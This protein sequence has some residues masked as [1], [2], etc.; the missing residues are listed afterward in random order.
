[1]RWRI[2]C[3]MV[4][5][6]D[7]QTKHLYITTS[8]EELCPKVLH[9]GSFMRQPYINIVDGG[10]HKCEH[11]VQGLVIGDAK[12]I[13]CLEKFIKGWQGRLCL[14]GKELTIHRNV[15]FMDVVSCH[16]N[17]QDVGLPPLGWTRVLLK[18]ATGLQDINSII[19]LYI[20]FFNEQVR[21]KSDSTVGE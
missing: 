16:A 1:M 8:V 13:M 7:W 4:T 10:L 19:T 3:W 21:Q 14:A 17:C 5:K 18:A 6:V 2:N 9:S 12:H 15:V 11:A 20:F